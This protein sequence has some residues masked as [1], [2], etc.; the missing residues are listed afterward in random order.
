MRLLAP[1]LAV[2]IL[3]GCFRSVHKSD[4]VG[5]YALDQGAGFLLEIK[6]D[7]TYLHTKIASDGTK[8]IRTG[9]WKWDE[10]DEDNPMYLEN[11]QVFPGEDIGVSEVST[12]YILHPE[13]SSQG[14]RFSVGDPDSPSHYFIKQ[15]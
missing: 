4:V 1:I 5:L 15:R 6:G 7:G 8:I 9:Q 14:L 11:F 2:V 12:I 3:T 10:K 13:N